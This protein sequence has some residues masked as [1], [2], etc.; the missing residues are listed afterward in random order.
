MEEEFDLWIKEQTEEWRLKWLALRAAT[1]LVPIFLYALQFGEPARI[2][3]SLAGLRCLLW[4]WSRLERDGKSCVG[5][6]EGASTYYLERHAANVRH[7]EDLAALVV[8]YAS[9]SQLPQEMRGN[10]PR[11]KVYS[12]FNLQVRARR[13]LT[14]FCELRK[15]EMHFLPEIWQRLLMEDWGIV[16]GAGSY[17]SMPLHLMEYEYDCAGVIPFEECG[18]WGKWLKAMEEGKP[19]SPDLQ[20]RIA[21]IPDPIWQSGPEEVAQEIARIEA[22][23]EAEQAAAASRAPEFEPKDVSHLFD[24][25]RSLG[26]TTYQT[27]I[28]INQS[29]ELFRQQTGLNDLP[30]MLKPLEAIPSSLEAIRDLVAQG[31]NDHTEQ[32]LRE[33]IGRLRSKIAKLEGELEKARRDPE[34]KK[35]TWFGNL[36]VVWPAVTLAGTFFWHVSG[37]DLG[38]KKRVEN[39]TCF[40]EEMV[41]Q[42]GLDCGP[43]QIAQASPAPQTLSGP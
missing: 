30:D 5:D 41:G 20:R 2:Q 18:F 15:M 19:L 1:R 11:D 21:L 43:E 3:P 37:D 32:A 36:G 10:F 28:T 9:S 34:L 7:P 12:L 24:Y 39:F 29:F 27:S 13:A 16:K 35:K 31:R 6:L 33:E 8:L 14:I 25:P 17:L 22:E 42:P 40:F 23:W 26:G 4:E 38:W